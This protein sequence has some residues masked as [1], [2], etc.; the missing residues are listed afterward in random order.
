M[1]TTSVLKHRIAERR[2]TFA[3]LNESLQSLITNEDW[4]I[5]VERLKDM[6]TVCAALRD[7]EN[8]MADR[9]DQ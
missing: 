1:I 8:Q 4:S 3:Q 2:A 6:T 5:V 7:Y 9:D